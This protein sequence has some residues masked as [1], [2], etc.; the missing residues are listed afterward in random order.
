MFYPRGCWC[1]RLIAP[2]LRLLSW[3]QPP[4]LLSQG[5]HRI[6]ISNNSKLQSKAWLWPRNKNGAV[7]E[8]AVLVTFFCC[9]FLFGH[10]TCTHFLET[11]T[12]LPS[13]ELTSDHL[14]LSAC[15][16][17]MLRSLWWLSYH[18]PL[19]LAVKQLR[20]WW[21]RDGWEQGSTWLLRPCLLQCTEWGLFQEVILMLGR[22]MIKF[23][24]SPHLLI[25]T[26]MCKYSSP[27]V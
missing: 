12:L 23:Q 27:L 2:T 18:A 4:S 13:G 16:L 8:R 24:C 10:P 26:P 14:Y 22:F 1:L 25:F 5:L 17:W 11:V 6:S 3:P 20:P 15:L 9:L 21:H 19:R 7:R